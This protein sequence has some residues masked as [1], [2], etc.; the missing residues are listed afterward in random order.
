MARRQ[1]RKK[2]GRFAKKYGRR[3]GP[4]TSFGAPYL[5]HTAEFS[6]CHTYRYLLRRVWDRQLPILY[7]VMLNPSTAGSDEDDPTVRKC[8]GFASRLGFGGIEIRNLFAFVTK[9]PT[10][11]NAVADPIGPRN[12]E[13]LGELPIADGTVLAAWGS[14]YRYNKAFADRAQ[15][16]IRVI[17]AGAEVS[18]GSWMC[19]GYTS[20]GDPRH[21][22]MLSYRTKL[23]PFPRR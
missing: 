23:E 12:G 2:D 17:E 8:V 7:F 15:A 20:W 5:E 11:L 21:P 9:D 4:D 13:F 16:L 22:L 19:L 18:A 14:R 1:I 3:S 6:E 10:R